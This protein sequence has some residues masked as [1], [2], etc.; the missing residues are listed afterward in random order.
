MKIIPTLLCAFALVGTSAIRAQE[1][2][3]GDMGKLSPAATAAPDDTS[4]KTGTAKRGPTEIT[5]TKE[6]SFDGKQRMAVFLG[7]V[8]IDDPEFTLKAEKLTVY[9]KKQAPA[10]PDEKGKPGAS[11]VAAKAGGGGLDR[12][13]AEGNVVI[14]KMQPDG[15]GG[16]P[17]RYVGKAAKVEYNAATGDAIL[18]GWPRV[19][20][21]INMHVATESS[22]VMYLNREGRMRTQGGSKTTIV[23][24]GPG[25]P[26]EHK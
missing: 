24:P 17:V 15:T 11:A 20:Q 7:D 2:S 19:L 8:R 25:N 18:S 3:P 26:L 6:A 22:T 12:A 4:K 1:A 16:Q 9:M 14:E 21:G 5:A 10:A 23:D 13:I